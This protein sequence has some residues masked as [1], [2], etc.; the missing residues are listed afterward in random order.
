MQV[1]RAQ[2][3]KHAWLYLGLPAPPRRIS[4]PGPAARSNPVVCAR[5]GRHVA[6]LWQSTRELCSVKG[7]VVVNL[8]DQWCGE[9]TFNATLYLY[10]YIVCVS[11]K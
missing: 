11:D 3:R 1:R 8:D 7:S 10:S 9:V 2:V 4:G 5:A 6:C